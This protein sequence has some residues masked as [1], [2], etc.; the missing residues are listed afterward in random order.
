[1][2]RL[3]GDFP[4]ELYSGVAEAFAGGGCAWQVRIL[5][6][7]E[8]VRCE[9]WSRAIDCTQFRWPGIAAGW[10]FEWLGAVSPAV[11][12]AGFCR[13]GRSRSPTSPWRPC[14]GVRNATGAAAESLAL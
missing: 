5:L 6:E 8:Y 13:A 14:D 9:C 2:G 11:S 10:R 4:D 7:S 12:I 3:V 1:M